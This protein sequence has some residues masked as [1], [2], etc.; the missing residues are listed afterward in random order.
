MRRDIGGH[1]RATYRRRVCTHEEMLQYA[2]YM[3]LAMYFAI[4]DVVVFQRLGTFM[5]GRFSKMICSVMLGA[6]EGRTWENEDLQKK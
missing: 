2:R 1:R 4:G 6:G 5:G 3:C